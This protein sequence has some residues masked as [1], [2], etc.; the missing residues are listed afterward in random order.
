MLRQKY[1]CTNSIS[2]N[3]IKSIMTCD[4]DET[5]SHTKIELLVFNM[6]THEMCYA[7]AYVPATELHIHLMHTCDGLAHSEL[8][9]FSVYV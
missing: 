9:L 2:E 4:T 7:T 8:F 1:V 3:Q 6:K 5:T